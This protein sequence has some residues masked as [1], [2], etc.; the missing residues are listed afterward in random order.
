MRTALE[1]AG[2]RKAVYAAVIVAMGALVALPAVGMEGP[3]RLGTTYIDHLSQSVQFHYYLQ[4]PDQAP[5]GLQRGFAGLPQS[6]SSGGAPS[7]PRFGPT[8]DRF[9]HD[10]DGLPQNEESVTVCPNRP[11]VVL[12]GTNDYRGLL[13][14]DQNFTGWDLSTDGGS[15]VLKEGLLPTANV[16]GTQTPSGGDPVVASDVNCGLY[17]ASLA[18]NPTDPMGQTTN[19][20]PPSG[21]VVYRTTPGTLRSSQCEDDPSTLSDPDCWQTSQAVAW[22]P[23]GKNGDFLDKEWMAVGDTGDGIH[24]WITY[25]DFTNDFSSPLGFSQAQ[26]YAVRCNANL[27]GCTAPILISSGDSDVAFSYVTIGPDHR[28]YVTWAGVTGELQS[29]P[30]R[31][32]PRIRVA[33]PGSTTFGPEHTVATLTKPLGFDTFLH[34]DDFRVA[35]GP[36]NDVGTVN[37]HP[38]VYLTYDVCGKRPLDTICEY[39]YIV[40]AWSDDQGSTWRSKTISAGG[41]NYFPTVAVDHVTG[42]VGV[43]WYTNRF[44]PFGHRQVVELVTLNGKTLG[45]LKRQELTRVQNEPDA[46]PLLGGAFIGDYFQMAAHAGLAYVAYNANYRQ[47]RLL[48]TGIPV[49]QQDNYLAVRH[50]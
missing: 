37:G 1:R 49:N 35:T 43:S 32:F 28:T 24:V 20:A 10:A 15:H 42:E 46:D 38:R 33:Q 19:P 2:V 6:S 47:V 22:K 29:Q 23:T 45:I 25:S 48:G 11:K 13:D 17:A 16:G 50:M 4:H 9:N 21:V 5:Q 7:A 31:F 3:R 40:L 12:S 18:Y 27:T 26:V 36:K 41:D 30:E 8:A 39:P 44:D 34:A 14:L